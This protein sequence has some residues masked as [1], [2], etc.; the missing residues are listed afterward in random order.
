MC[1]RDSYRIVNSRNSHSDDSSDYW[2]EYILVKTSIYRYI[3]KNTTQKYATESNPENKYAGQKIWL[4]LIKIIVR[5]L[6]Y[7]SVLML[8]SK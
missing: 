3:K 1:I 6:K 5:S 8:E 2:I 7:A 4:L